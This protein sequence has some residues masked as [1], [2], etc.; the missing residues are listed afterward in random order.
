L[1]IVGGHRSEVSFRKVNP[2][3]QGWFLIGVID[4]ILAWP[5]QLLYR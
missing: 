2:K 1:L 3:A 4:L 5:P